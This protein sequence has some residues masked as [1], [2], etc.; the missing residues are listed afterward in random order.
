MLNR[1]RRC[2]PA[3]INTQKPR[4]FCISL[5]FLKFSL[6]HTSTKVARWGLV[7]TQPCL[8][9]TCLP[10]I[11]LQSQSPLGYLVGRN[12]ANGVDLNRNFPDLNTVMYY[13]EKQGGPNHHIPLPDNWRSQVTYYCRLT[14]CLVCLGVL[15]KNNTRFRTPLQGCGS[16][17]SPLY[18]PSLLLSPQLPHQFQCCYIQYPSPSLLPISSTLGVLFQ[19]HRPMATAGHMGCLGFIPPT[20]QTSEGCEVHKVDFLCGAEVKFI[21]LA[22]LLVFHQKP[23]YPFR[24]SMYFQDCTTSQCRQGNHIF[25]DPLQNNLSSAHIK[26][27]HSSLAQAYGLLGQM[28]NSQE[29]SLL[30]PF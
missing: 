6:T 4:D 22:I 29:S 10:F 16:S 9:L 24:K 17:G 23:I 18:D 13:N 1:V 25:E 8:G 19:C 5:C 20:N 11:L 30:P 2:L 21:P 3:G 15:H 28:P 14:Q 7:C 27:A 26:V 12:N